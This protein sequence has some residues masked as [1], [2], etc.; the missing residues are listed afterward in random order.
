MAALFKNEPLDGNWRDLQ[1]LADHVLM[2]VVRDRGG[3]RTNLE[4]DVHKVEMA[5]SKAFDEG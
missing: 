5:I 4:W 1:R 2:E 3:R